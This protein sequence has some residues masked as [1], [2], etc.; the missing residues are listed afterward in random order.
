MRSFRLLVAALLLTAAPQPGPAGERQDPAAIREAA[1]RF[2]RERLTSADAARV[3]A[4]RIDERLRLEACGEPLE[5]FAVSGGRIGS[6]TSIGVRCADRWKLYVPVR[7]ETPQRVVALARP[8]RRGEVLT[9]G[10][11]EFV[12]ADTQRLQQGYFS[13]VDA[14]IGQRLARSVTPGTILNHSMLKRIALIETGQS[15]TLIAGTGGIAVSAPGK[16][17]ASGSAG[18]RIK[19]RNLSSGRIV[20]GVIRDGDHVAVR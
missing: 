17:L 9:A 20:E 15:V 19:V 12:A 1:E 13:A 7:V 16:A 6:N 14:L 4:D 5:A 3:V 18:D 10:D 2:V 11:L 8:V